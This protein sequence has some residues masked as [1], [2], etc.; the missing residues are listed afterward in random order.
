MKLKSRRILKTITQQRLAVEITAVEIHRS[1]TAGPKGLLQRSLIKMTA[2]C[3]IWWKILQI[4]QRYQLYQWKYVELL[5]QCKGNVNNDLALCSC[6]VV[7]FCVFSVD[8]YMLINQLLKKYDCCNFFFRHT[9]MMKLMMCSTVA[10]WGF[11]L[12]GVKQQYFS[13]GIVIAIQC[14]LRFV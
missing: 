1:A 7:Y 3:S 10:P 6:V 14:T 13:I 8:F 12:V 5:H 9:I 11:S 4:K 2:A